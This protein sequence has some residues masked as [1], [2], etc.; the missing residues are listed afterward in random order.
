M[1]KIVIVGTNEYAE[2][3]F[4]AIRKDK[5]ADVVAFATLKAFQTITEYRGLPVYA[6][7]DLRDY[8]DM[9]ECK[10]LIC[11]G[12]TEMNARRER[13]YLLCKQLNYAIYCIILF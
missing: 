12:Y 10:V 5:V 11:V 3:V 2:Y 7:E 13:T 1:D 4:E 6:V 9:D 8:L